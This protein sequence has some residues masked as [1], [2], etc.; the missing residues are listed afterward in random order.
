MRVL[1]ICRKRLGD[2]LQCF[3]AARHLRDRGHEVFIESD[4]FYHDIFAC[5]DYAKPVAPFHRRGM[6][7]DKVFTM[8]IDP[9]G[10]GTHRRF[11]DYR[12]SGKTWRQFVYGEHQEFR[13]A[14]D[15]PIVFTK[16]DWCSQRDY[17]FPTNVETVVL[18]PHGYSQIVRYPI[19]K[20]EA[21]CAVRWP[22]LPLF[23]LTDSMRGH[24]RTL[25]A[26]RLRDLPALIT[27][28]EHFAA[29]NSAPAIIA[30]AVRQHY[31]HFPQTG[32]AAVDDT[33]VNGVSEIALP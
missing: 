13:K 21:F 5:V 33:A 18:A 9:S 32:C 15:D 2:I 30:A 20:L 11:M 1:F 19:P 3:P 4:V 10:G 16:I 24:T 31:V 12:A 6:T 25:H 26:K 28:P 7:Y 17:K 29:I 27:W 14:V 8:A 22:G 23:I